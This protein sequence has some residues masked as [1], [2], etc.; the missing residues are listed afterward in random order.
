MLWSSAV[1][2]RRQLLP[3]ATTFGESLD[4]PVIAEA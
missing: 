1:E 2:S 4:P 3:L